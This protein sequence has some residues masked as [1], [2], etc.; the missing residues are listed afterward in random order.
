MAC[1]SFLEF[2]PTQNPP[3]RK[4]ITETT[5]APSISDMILEIV[6]YR[7]KYEEIKKYNLRQRT[8][9]IKNIDREFLLQSLLN[10]Q[11]EEGIGLQSEED[12][13]T[14]LDIIET[15]GSDISIKKVSDKLK[16]DDPRQMRHSSNDRSRPI[17]RKRSACKRQKSGGSS[18]SPN[19]DDDEDS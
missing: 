6:S 13:K 14:V 1:G 17:S 15:E 3:W 19:S 2:K 5:N 9:M 10:I 18:S 7:R 4:R 8:K 16:P 12:T 11:R